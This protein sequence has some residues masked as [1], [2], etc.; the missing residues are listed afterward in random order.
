MGDIA[1]SLSRAAVY[2]L[3]LEWDTAVS[4]LRQALLQTVQLYGADSNEATELLIRL[5]RN[6]MKL[7]HYTDANEM[8]TVAVTNSVLCNGAVHVSTI[9]LLVNRS[10]ACKRLGLTE[11][12]A[13]LLQQA[14]WAVLRMSSRP[15]ELDV[16]T[17]SLE[18]QSFEWID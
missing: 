13:K 16:I 8:L 3:Q 18:R 4:F 11:Q 10:Y 6:F 14:L 5:A 1:E 17:T 12:Q 2:E 9:K 15:K 7:G